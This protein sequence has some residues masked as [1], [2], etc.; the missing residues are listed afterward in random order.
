MFFSF[1]TG[2]RT[3]ENNS[4]TST[5]RSMQRNALRK[6]GI[7]FKYFILMMNKILHYIDKIVSCQC[8]VEFYS[9]MDFFCYLEFKIMIDKSF[10]EWG[11]TCPLWVLVAEKKLVLCLEL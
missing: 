11:N 3:D 5:F 4:H 1:Q 7:T 6:L 2:L 9:S 10:A 8:N